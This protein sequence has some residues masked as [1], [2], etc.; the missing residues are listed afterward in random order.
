VRVLKLTDDLKYR[1]P[2]DLAALAAI[3]N[4]GD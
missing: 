3:T 1:H 2:D 4:E